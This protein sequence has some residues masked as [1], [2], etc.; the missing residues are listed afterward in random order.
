MKFPFLDFGVGK[1][2]EVK[3]T[4]PQSD[5]IQIVLMKDDANYMIYLL[6]Q[7]QNKKVIINTKEG[8]VWGTAVDVSD[9]YT[10]DSGVPV[11]IE[12]DAKD[13]YFDVSANNKLLKK[14]DYR[15]PA[16]DVTRV[17]YY[18]DVKLEKLSMCLYKAWLPELYSED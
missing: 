7:Y 3:F 6:I 14:F 13:E 4:G 2:V 11:T 8:G 12:I 18:S 15:Y 5:Q 16:T 1:A 9:E 10:F 17:A